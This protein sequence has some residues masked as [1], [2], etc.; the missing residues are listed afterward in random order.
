MCRPQ[1]VAHSRIEEPDSARN[2]HLLIG[3]M[4]LDIFPKDMLYLK[5][6]YH[7]TFLE[8]QMNVL[9]WKTMC[10][11]MLTPY[12]LY[13]KSVNI[14]RMWINIQTY[15]NTLGTL[16]NNSGV[17]LNDPVGDL[18]SD[19]GEPTSVSIICRNL[20][21]WY[22]YL[23]FLIGEHVIDVRYLYTF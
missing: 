6:R 18:S 3:G 19:I 5:R 7:L 23:F 20:L 16:L 2:R 15:R 11:E 17:I 8:I 21:I 14:W 13:S 1:T 10:Y 12:L 9:T 4:F 22:S